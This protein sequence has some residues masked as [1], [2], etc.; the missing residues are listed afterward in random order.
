MKLAGQHGQHIVARQLVLAGTAEQYVVGTATHQHIVPGPAIEFVGTMQLTSEQQAAFVAPQTVVA[1]APRQNVV[2][3]TAGQSIIACAALEHVASVGQQ[4]QVC[5]RLPVCITDDMGRRCI[6][7]Q[8]ICAITTHQHIVA[9]TTFEVVV[10]GFAVQVVRTMRFQADKKFAVGATGTVAV[11]LVGATATVQD[12]GVAA[13]LQMV[14]AIATINEVGSMLHRQSGVQVTRQHHAVR[15]HGVVAVARL[16]EVGTTHAV[17]VVVPGAAGDTVVATTANDIVVARTGIDVISIDTRTCVDHAIPHRQVCAVSHHAPG[18]TTCQYRF[19]NRRQPGIERPD[20]LQI[21]TQA[22][23]SSDEVASIAAFD[24]IAARTTGNQVV[25]VAAPQHVVPGATIEC[26]V[27][28]QATEL[29][30]ACR[31]I[32][33]VVGNECACAAH[34]V[35]VSA[36]HIP[37]AAGGYHN[38]PIPHQRAIAGDLKY[39][40]VAVEGLPRRTGV[41]QLDRPRIRCNGFAATVEVGRQHGRTTTL[42]RALLQQADT[43]LGLTLLKVNDGTICRH[44]CTTGENPKLV[45]Q[46][47]QCQ[48]Q[49]VP[50]LRGRAQEHREHAGA[51]LSHGSLT[52]E[53]VGVEIPGLKR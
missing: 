46:G 7:P 36:Y 2:A 6:T 32:Q 22:S 41:L 1:V 33:H 15:T 49:T 4:C 19:A 30:V 48:H 23:A 52:S 34:Q 17:D 45:S 26:V 38:A 35:V 39:R 28:T 16:N 27:A 13:T 10:P 3:A 43:D 21:H 18:G 31:A 47:R 5:C 44:R 40:V 20:L 14:V 8:D 53:C 24:L 25:A 29:V 37:G 42:Y 12:V 11:N 50:R 51:A 9:T